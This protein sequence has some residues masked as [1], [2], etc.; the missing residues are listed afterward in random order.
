M[1]L[2]SCQYTCPWSSASGTA[3]CPAE[4]EL[5]CSDEAKHLLSQLNRDIFVAMGE[6][7]KDIEGLKQGCSLSSNSPLLVFFACIEK[8]RYIN[9]Q[10]NVQA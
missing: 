3:L 8:T 4:G 5:Q 9:F 10:R 6:T 7:V 1:P 2:N